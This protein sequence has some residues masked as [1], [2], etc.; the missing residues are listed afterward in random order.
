[1]NIAKFFTIKFMKR[2]CIIWNKISF[3][4]R[5]IQ[6]TQVCVYLTQI[7]RNTDISVNPIGLSLLDRLW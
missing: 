2:G 6:H 4:I 7:R 5:Y 3:H 1:M